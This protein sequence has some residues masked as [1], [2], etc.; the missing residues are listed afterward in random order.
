MK[1]ILVGVAGSGKTAVGKAL[2]KRLNLPFFDGDDYHTPACKAKMASGVPLTD[3][4]RAP[5]LK[6]LSTLLQKHPSLILACSALK[7]RYRALLK[8]SPDV[9]F[10]Y[11][12]GDFA[13]IQKRL[14]AR[15]DHFFNPALLESQFASLE[16]PTDAIVVDISATIPE[17]V[18]QISNLVIRRL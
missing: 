6:T 3:E 1:I 10:I 14:E 11:L 2:A 7:N 15:K 9:V 16:E 5:W 17:I 12:K 13:L 4:D 18:T 8:V